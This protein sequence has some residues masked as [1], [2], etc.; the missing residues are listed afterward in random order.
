MGLATLLAWRIKMPDVTL[1][2]TIE[3]DASAAGG[4]AAGGGSVSLHGFDNVDIDSNGF[5]K[6][7]TTGTTTIGEGGIPHSTVFA[8]QNRMKMPE[9]FLVLKHYRS[10]PN[11]IAFLFIAWLMGIGIGLIF[12][13]LFW[14]L[15]V[16]CYG[17]LRELYS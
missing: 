15:Q 7:A 12:T 5:N 8:Q 11:C 2:P 4:L 10:S 17:N 16:R 6:P 1:I 9:W 3:M 14:H 13:F